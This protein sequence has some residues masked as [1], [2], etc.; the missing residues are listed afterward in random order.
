[1]N[2]SKF[3]KIKILISIFIFLFSISLTHKAAA[4]ESIAT[5]SDITFTFSEPVRNS[6]NSYIT[7][8]NVGSLITLKNTDASGLNISFTATINTAK[9]IITINPISNLTSHQIVYASID[10]GVEDYY[11][12][13]LPATSKI[14][15][16]EYLATSLTNPLNEK[17]VVGLIK[18]QPEIAKRM[19]QHSTIAVLKRMEWLRR[20]RDENNLSRQGIKLN[21]VNSTMADIANLSLIPFVNKTSNLFENDWAIWSEGSLTIGEIEKD[22]ISSVR[23]IKSNGITIGI[24]KIVDK[25][26]MYGAA[27]RIEDD[28]TIIFLIYYFYIQ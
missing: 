28:K 21:F 15:Q 25:N 6:D 24:D 1:M 9:T 7:D 23:G 13:A 18:E 22:S 5:D 4:V 26:Q 16:A 27:I 3:T 8:T 11:D 19:I 10:A 17:D 2:Y 14:F 20:H 12:N